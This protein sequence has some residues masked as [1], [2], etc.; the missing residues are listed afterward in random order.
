[1]SAPTATST[2]TAIA[3]AMTPARSLNVLRGPTGTT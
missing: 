3:E 2:V 1:M